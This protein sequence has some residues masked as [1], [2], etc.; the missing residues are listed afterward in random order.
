[1]NDAQLG[2]RGEFLQAQATQ[3]SRHKKTTIK[4]LTPNIMAAEKVSK[5]L[6]PAALDD[7]AVLLERDVIGVGVL[8]SFQKLPV[9]TTDA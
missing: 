1:V 8:C 3:L 5:D 6:E 7:R 9:A 4:I 2:H